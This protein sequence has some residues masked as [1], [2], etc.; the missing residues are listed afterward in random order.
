MSAEIANQ[1]NS[2]HFGFE[3]PEIVLQHDFF[4]KCC[5]VNK[6]YFIITVAGRQST[7]SHLNCIKSVKFH[8]SQLIEFCKFVPFFMTI[9]ARQLNYIFFSYQNQNN[10]AFIQFSLDFTQKLPSIFVRFY[11]EIAYLKKKPA[12]MLTHNT[13]FEI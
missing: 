3:K 6:Q 5:E 11:F 10:M 7:K 12:L 1:K 8:L 2:N 13:P 9:T 4:S